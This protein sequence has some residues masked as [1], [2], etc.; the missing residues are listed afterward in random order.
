MALGLMVMYE[1]ETCKMASVLAWNFNWHIV[2]SPHQT[3]YKFSVET[4]LH[5]VSYLELKIPT[6]ISTSVYIG[7]LHLFGPIY[8]VMIITSFGMCCGIKVYKIRKCKCSEYAVLR[9]YCLEYSSPLAQIQFSNKVNI[10]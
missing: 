8:S 5:R 2:L 6:A 9:S 7:L 4:R 1:R 3:S 10:R